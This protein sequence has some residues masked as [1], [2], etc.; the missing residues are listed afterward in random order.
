LKRIRITI[1]RKEDDEK[2]VKL[3]EEEEK[4]V[5]PGQELNPRQTLR[6]RHFN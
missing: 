4:N 1:G 5:R 6:G 3:E 2:E